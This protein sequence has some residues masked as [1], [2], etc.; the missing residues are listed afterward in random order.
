MSDKCLSFN[1]SNQYIIVP[2][3]D[4]FN[5]NDGSFTIA[6]RLKFI[7]NND[8]KDILCKFGTYGVE[9]G[10]KLGVYQNKIMLTLYDTGPG[11]IDI[12]LPATNVSGIITMSDRYGYSR[13]IN[14]RDWFWVAFVVDK[15]LLKGYIYINGARYESDYNFTT[16]QTV[17]LNNAANM[18][19]GNNYSGSYYYNGYLRDIRIHNAALTEQHI[20]AI[21]NN[22]YGTKY[23]AAPAEGGHANWASNCDTGTGDILEDAVGSVDGTLY[24][25]SNN[26]MWVEVGSSAITNSIA[27]RTVR[28]RIA[29]LTKYRTR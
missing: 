1:G 18:V 5:V 3:S 13:S 11:S 19:I 16:F 17:N 29:G 9:G 21:Y 23:T 6:L 4:V 24:G 22:G 7:T 8:N 10:Y 20:L 14:T 25:N 27:Q 28:G 26:N 15:V 2:D 12:Y